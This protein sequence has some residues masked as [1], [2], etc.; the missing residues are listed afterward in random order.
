MFLVILNI[1]L[2][3][4]CMMDLFSAIIVFGPL[5]LPVAKAF[6][7]HPV[8]L[9]I[10]FL[11]NLEIGYLMPPIG[12][13]LF[14]SSVRFKKPMTDL[15]RDTFPFFIILIFALMII[16]YVPELSLFLVQLMGSQ[17]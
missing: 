5:I 11:T 10:I 3:I 2:L 16:T 12:I 7:V 6:D 9:G 15:Y 8:H 13:N 17:N 14:I 4:A 1:F